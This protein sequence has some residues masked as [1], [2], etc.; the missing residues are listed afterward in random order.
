MQ[1]AGD[2]DGRKGLADGRPRPAALNGEQKVRCSSDVVVDKELLRAYAAARAAGDGMLSIRSAGLHGAHAASSACLIE[3]L[4]KQEQTRARA[5]Y[6]R[7]GSRVAAL[8]NGFD[9]QGRRRDGAD[10]AKRVCE[11]RAGGDGRTDLRQGTGLIRRRRLLGRRLSRFFALAF[12]SAFEVQS[13]DACR[14]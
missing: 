5:S 2:G 9:R 11:R 6:E 3:G 14:A 12:A 4:G 13:G 7:D 8:Y 1:G 10:D